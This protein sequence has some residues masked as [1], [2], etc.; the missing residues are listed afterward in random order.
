MFGVCFSLNGNTIKYALYWIE[1]HPVL[2]GV[3]TTIMGV[4]ITVIIGSFWF[5]K[6][7]RQ[8]RAEAFFGFY[9]RLLLQLNSLQVWLNEKELLNTDSN[10]IKQGNIYALM[11]NPATLNEVCPGF[12]D[13]STD[14]L[15][16]LKKLTLQ[17]KNTLLESENNV[18]PKHSQKKSWYNSQLILFLFCDFIE[19][20][21]LRKNISHPKYDSGDNSGNYK[22]IV[23]CNEL[24][25][26]MNSIQSS[27]NSEK[28]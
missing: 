21:S 12:H 19:Q 17:L 7:L 2:M 13:L 27:I 16:D 9:A 11:Y 15:S 6:F 4:I 14:D 24:I 20:D 22:H 5:R 10:N 23:K 18:Y 26:A 3:I 1:K 8:K 25:I 28:Y